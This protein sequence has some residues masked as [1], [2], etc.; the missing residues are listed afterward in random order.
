MAKLFSKGDRLGD[1]FVVEMF[2]AAGGQGISYKAKDDS[3]GRIVFLKQL[4]A[5]IKTTGGA[6]AYKRFQREQS[7]DLASKHIPKVLGS[8]EQEGSC[9]LVTQFI[10]GENLQEKLAKRKGPFCSAETKDILRQAAEGLQ[11][12][13]DEGTVHRDIKLENLMVTPSGVVMIV[14]WGICRFLD[15][16]TIHDSSDPKGTIP[17]MS[18]EHIEGRGVDCQSDLYSLGVVGYVCQAAQYPFDGDTPEEMFHNIL[19]TDA[20]P[21]RTLNPATDEDLEHIVAKLMAKKKTLRYPDARALIHDLDR[22]FTEDGGSVCRK[23]G[24][25]VAAGARFCDSCKIPESEPCEPYTAYLLLLNGM[26]KGKKLFVRPDGIEVGRCTLG[27]DDDFISRRHSKIYF[28]EGRFWIED[29]GSLNGTSVNS[30][31]VPKGERRPLVPGDH[32]RFADTF[33]EFARS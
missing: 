2:L 11:V 13:H 23:C 8:F 18:R 28:A 17:F 29:V 30:S 3:T 15:Q 20:I 12:A 4:N 9:F 14:D 22:G 5:D 6:I 19:H 33:C 16:R 27:L 24:A 1:K 26:N 31:L 7:I 10:E 25:A 32:I 21:L